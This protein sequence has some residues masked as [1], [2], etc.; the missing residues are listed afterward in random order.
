MPRCPFDPEETRQGF[1]GLLNWGACPLLVNVQLTHPLTYLYFG[2]SN[3]VTKP[4]VRCKAAP[5]HHF[6]F[7]L[8]TQQ[9]NPMALA[10]KHT[11]LL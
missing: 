11:K 4:S 6:W 10:A 7:L 5:S 9:V 8:K 3:P 1:Q 2:S